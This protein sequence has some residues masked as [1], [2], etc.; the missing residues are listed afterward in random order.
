M[1][2]MNTE[3]HDE[4]WRLLGKAKKTEVS[5]FFARNVLRE[6]RAQQP[7]RSGIFA[8]VFRQWRVAALTLSAITL[9]GVGF[10][11]SFFRKPPVVTAPQLLAQQTAPDY[12]AINHLD[13]L[14]AYE[15]TSVWLDNSSY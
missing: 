2:T 4:L 9:L 7:A 3:E 10:A 13:E 8:R 5:P 14:L 11:P 1:K 6:I 12:D 15:E